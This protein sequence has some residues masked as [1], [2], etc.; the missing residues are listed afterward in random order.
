MLTRISVAIAFSVPLFSQTYTQ[1][2][3][4][5]TRITMLGA[6]HGAGTNIQPG[7][8][9]D[10]LNPQNKVVQLAGYP[11]RASNGD[12]TWAWNGTKT[13]NCYAIGPAGG[14]GGAAVWGS[15][16]GVL[17][18]QA[19]L[20]SALNLKTP[21]P[22][23][24]ADA[25]GGGQLN[26]SNVF[27]AGTVPAV[28]LGTGGTGT[29]Y[30]RS[31]GTWATPPGG[32]GGGT[33]GSITGT[34]S[35]QTDLQNALNL[36]A[37]LA[38]P[39]FTGTPTIP[40]FALAG[41]SHIDAAGGGQLDAS[42][43]FS[44]GIVPAA[45]L[46][47]GGNGTNFLRS[48][49]TFATP[50]G[51]TSGI[52]T[53]PELTDVDDAVLPTNRFTLVGNGTIFQGRTL[54]TTDIVTGTFVPARIASGTASAG[55]TPISTGP[56]LPPVWTAP[57]G[58]SGTVTSITA[59]CAATASPSPITATGIISHRVL[60]TANSATTY[61]FVTTDCGRLMS[62][63]NA[64]GVTVTLPTIDG[65]NFYVGWY[66]HIQN[67]NA[68]GNTV[69]TPATNTID[70]VAG[71]LTLLPGQGVLLAATA[72]QYYTSRGMGTG[73]AAGSL[74]PFSGTGKFIYTADGTTA[75]WAS[76][77]GGA[78][79][80]LDYSNPL[81][82]DFVPDCLETMAWDWTGY[83]N[84]STG[85]LRVPEKTYT[86]LPTASTNT[87]KEYNVTDCLTTACTAGGG[88]I[89]AKLRSNG[90]T[91]VCITCG[92]GGTV[93]QSAGYTWT[94]YHNHAT[95]TIRLPE[96]VFASLPTASTNTG[97]VYVVTNC[98]TNACTAGGGTISK[99]LRSNG[100]AWECM[101][102]STASA[103][104][105]HQK[106][107]LSNHTIGVTT[108]TVVPGASLYTTT[109][110]PLNGQKF[111]IAICKIYLTIAVDTAPVNIGIHAPDGTLLA[112]ATTAGASG[113]GGQVLTADI[114]PDLELDPAVYPAV[115]LGTAPS[116]AA[117]AVTYATQAYT[118]PTSQ[119]R[120]GGNSSLA[121]TQA[122]AAG[123]VPSPLAMTETAG[124][125][126]FPLIS[127]SQ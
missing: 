111:T 8:C 91:W 86:T 50:P 74:P 10:N 114:S 46:G 19:D 125:L 88:T 28:R 68:T 126:S 12:L 110:V 58:G 95:G 115:Y 23:T 99:Q 104:V 35:D 22:H 100:T 119:L 29:N 64:A 94:G 30:L 118:T 67:R 9:W 53:L 38:S 116:T 77:T 57:A 49:G 81:A 13:G 70:G 122:T 93:D 31:D 108:G 44:T 40:S 63:S 33:W 117:A 85:A 87:G 66:V 121:G 20:Q 56:G 65:T 76:L 55:F 97:K 54:D 24:H 75:I 92:G 4:A 103:I 1:P 102:C 39:V 34:L 84:M 107:D 37:P 18:S 21:L 25:P 47:T 17:S 109:L 14:G 71:S 26:A 61:T 83:H 79:N 7:E 60:P 112:S 120:N 45:R 2:F 41:H 106:Q 43:V 78:T 52:T 62:F 69:I 11:R 3:T 16:T 73:G 36:K 89:V 5:S 6:T 96:V 48:D 42:N 59:S 80:C 82:P 124:S 15:I 90:T 113:T 101:G 105:A 123:A 32:A 27:S 51:G 98:A 127:C 72:S